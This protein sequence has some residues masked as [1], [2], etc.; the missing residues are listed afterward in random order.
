MLDAQGLET[1]FLNARTHSRWKDQEVPDGLLKSIYETLKMAPTSANG[2][3]ARFLF[4]RTP[5]AKKRL[6][7]C[8][9]PGNVEKT[10]KA[11][12]N[13]VIAY[14]LDFY[15][16]L[17]KLHPHADAKSWFEGNENLIQETAFRNSS[18]QGAYLILA[19][20]AYGLDCGP[21]SGFD[22]KLLD[23]TFFEHTHVRSNFLC[24]LGY[25]DPEGLHPRLPRLSFEE[26][27]TLL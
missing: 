15:L 13:V 1:L 3:P 18:L 24:N 23:Q 22:A 11:P 6:L 8:L 21:M 26:A 2:S 27:C 9:S 16:K 10:L 17:P 20:R 14:D 5:E 4:I 19:A 7:P 12:V 25:G